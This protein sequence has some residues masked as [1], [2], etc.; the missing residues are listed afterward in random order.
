MVGECSR[1]KARVDEVESTM[2]ET[3]ESMD[4]LQAELSEA[5]ASKLFLKNRAKTIEDQVAL[6]HR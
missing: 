6:L 3:L 4:K 5:N 2:K 1:L